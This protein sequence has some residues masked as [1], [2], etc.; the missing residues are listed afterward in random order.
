MISPTL[1]V[2]LFNKFNLS[3]NSWPV[4]IAIIIYVIMFYILS[5]IGEVEM[6]KIRSVNC[7]KIENEI[8]H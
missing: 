6:Y 4:F 2:F 8:G 5:D 1:M 3:I 7:E